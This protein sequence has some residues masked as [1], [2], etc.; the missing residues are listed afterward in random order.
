VKTK[1]DEARDRLIERLKDFDFASYIISR[2]CSVT[3]GDAHLVPGRDV[4]IRFC[5]Y[6]KA[7]V[8]T[9]PKDF[10]GSTHI[11]GERGE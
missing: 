5:D 7:P 8:A 6:R 11:T 2:E 1:Y 4:T 10:A 3:A 9:M